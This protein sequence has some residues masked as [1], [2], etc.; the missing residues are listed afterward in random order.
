[1]L[2]D[3]MANPFININEGSGILVGNL[4]SL[5]GAFIPDNLPHREEEISQMSRLLGSLM[6]NTRPSN[7][8]VYGRTGT[9]KTST[10]RYV[11]KML[12]EATRGSVMVSYINCQIY[13]SQY[14]ILITLVNF[15]S[16]SEEEHIPLSGWPMDRIYAE[17]VRRMQESGKFLLIILDE[18]DKLVAKGGSDS[19]Y[20]I[21]KLADD[22]SAPCSSIIGITNNTSFTESLDARVRSRLNQESLLFPPY[23]ANELKDILAYRTNGL[24]KEGVLEESAMNLCAAIG[25]REHGDA[26]KALD[27]LRIAID[28]SVRDS[29]EKVTEV[30]VI[31]ARDRLEVDILRES[32]RSLPL[33]SKILLLSCVVT[34]EMGQRPTLT[35]E[36]FENYCNICAELGYQSLSSRR[37]GDMLSDL[38]DTGLISSKIQSMGRYGRSRLIQ[39]AENGELLKKYLLEEDALSSFRGRKLG[40]QVRF[41][42]GD[43]EST[44]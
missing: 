30:E 20:V 14:S 24:L 40:R 42:I 22:T 26:R 2:P 11:V 21:L 38:D 12:T 23:D 1:M 32:I 9:G 3:F 16:R 39:L 43:E 27:L 33:H 34:Q 7:I 35:G 19:L 17:L 13:D 36:I 18:I 15:F 31:S 44:G 41:K 6:R 4:S 10:T 5:G 37:I 29:K 8:M 28:I 25:A